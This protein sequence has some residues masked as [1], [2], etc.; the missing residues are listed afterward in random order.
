[1]AEG[2]DQRYVRTRVQLHGLA[3]GL[4]AGPQYRSAGTI[5]LSVYADGFGG[6]ASPLSI[7]GMR[8]DW[9]D[10]S[11][12]LAGTPRE[13]ARAA[14]VDF[15][16]PED[17][18][19]AT[20]LVDAETT[21]AVDEAA[22]TLIIRSH[23]AG[24]QALRQLFTEQQPVLWPEHFDVAVSVSDV[25]YGVSAG[26][27]YHPTPYAYVGPWIPRTG[28]FWNAPF[29]AAYPLNTNDDCAELIIGIV[30]FFE[31]GTAELEGHAP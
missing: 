3:D 22:A 2:F 31:Q 9:A 8:F 26:D 20:G 1:M 17:V 5:R 10:G 7:R 21:L 11:A 16:A 25:N 15:G 14:G 6:A 23:H 24:S 28:S 12:P 19:P 13:L 18:Y 30:E 29:G 4:I 27:G